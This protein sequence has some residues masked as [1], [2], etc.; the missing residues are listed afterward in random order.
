ML[1]KWGIESSGSNSLRSNW[2]L[3]PYEIFWIIFFVNYLRSD[4]DEKVEF[5][6]NERPSVYIHSVS[7]QI[8]DRR[9]KKNNTLPIS[10]AVIFLNAVI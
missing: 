3:S 5:G 6:N 7:T 8:G 1:F 4:T 9:T 10:L 2:I